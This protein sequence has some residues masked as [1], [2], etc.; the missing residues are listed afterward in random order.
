MCPW[1]D[2]NGAKLDTQVRH[3]VLRGLRVGNWEGAGG[4]VPARGNEP[5]LQALEQHVTHTALVLIS[6]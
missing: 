6:S 4:R 1:G 2:R 5:V 3:D